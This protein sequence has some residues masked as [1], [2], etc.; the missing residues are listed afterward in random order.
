MPAQR[1]EKSPNTALAQL[2]EESGAS[3]A[4]LSH[5]INEL[6]RRAG[7]N[8]TYQHTSIAN[9]VRRGM[10]PRPPAPALLAAVLG[11]RL[12]RPVSLDE[13]G[14][15]DMRGQRQEIGFDFSRDPDEALRIA[16]EYWSTVDRRTFVGSGP[17]AISAFATPVN[18]WLAVPTDPPAEHRRG[19][20][21]V[22]RADLDELWEAA[23]EARRW[24]SKF[25]GGNWK[26]NSVTDCL[27]HRAAP[28]L[29]GTFTDAIGRELFTVTAELARVAAWSAF[30]KGSHDIAQQHF[31]QALRLARSSGDL[32]AGSYVLATMSLT[33]TLNGYPQEAIDMAQGAYERAKHSAAP[34][35]L[36][37]AKLTEARAH[38]RAGD[39]RGA[40]AALAAS[41]NLLDSIRYDSRDPD[42]LSYLT[43]ARISAD[44]TEIY[45]DLGKPTAARRWNEQ[46]DAMPPGVFTRAVGIRMAVVGTTYLQSRDLDRGLEMGG[47]A[48]DILG[49]V[50]SARAHDYIHGLITALEPWRKEAPVSEFIRRS[51]TALAAA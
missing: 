36:A 7:V 34:R 37:F 51:N 33:A 41:E 28:L 43:H 5:R 16:T 9:W 21:R 24:D 19:R 6:A 32:Q 23:D 49:R 40:A 12:G 39:A 29:A 35:V 18:R 42:W 31:I 48:V 38:G 47:R 44:A 13:I 17:F 15:G 2:I 11:E 8:R 10:R 20:R 3:S 50:Q 27:T 25:G 46:A 4:A 14:M 22:G 45:R 30:D 26:A 1:R